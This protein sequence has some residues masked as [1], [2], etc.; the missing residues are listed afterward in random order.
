VAEHDRGRRSSFAGG[1]FRCRRPSDSGAPTSLKNGRAQLGWVCRGEMNEA[2]RKWVRA[3]T[4]GGGRDSDLAL[5][6]TW[7]RRSWRAC[8]RSARAS[9]WR[10]RGGD[11]HMVPA[12]QWHRRTSAQWARA[13]TRRPHWAERERAD[14]LARRGADMTG[15]HGGE[16][17]EG[18]RRARLRANWAERLEQGE[19]GLLWFSHLFLNFLFLFLLFSLVNSIQI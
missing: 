14:E 11:W 18:G 3:G 2:E 4:W 5:G 9:G 6:A 15:P 8:K 10:R 19:A 1:G 13:P 17:G 12:E 7:G 16:S